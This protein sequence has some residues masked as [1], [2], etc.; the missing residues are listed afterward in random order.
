[1]SICTLQDLPH[2]E[3]LVAYDFLYGNIF[4]SETLKEFKLVVGQ[5]ILSP[6]FNSNTGNKVK[7]SDVPFFFKTLYSIKMRYHNFFYH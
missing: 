4:S 2:T 1:M 5:D 6:D 7:Y 3:S